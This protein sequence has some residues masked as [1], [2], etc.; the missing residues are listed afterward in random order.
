MGLDPFGKV[1]PSCARSVISDAHPPGDPLLPFQGNSPCAAGNDGIK[2]YFVA[3]S[4]L[5]A[6]ALRR[7]RSETRLRAQCGRQNSLQEGL[8]LICSANMCA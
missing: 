5:R 8:L 4:A 1:G 3:I 2:P 6:A 7:L